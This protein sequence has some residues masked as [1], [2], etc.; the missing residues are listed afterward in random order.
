MNLGVLY[1][2]DPFTPSVLY[3]QRYHRTKLNFQFLI[4]ENA[5]CQRGVPFCINSEKE[6]ETFSA[7]ISLTLN[8]LNCPN[9]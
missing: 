8:D 9:N 1:I 4:Y 6:T 2:N 7:I 5:A 3:S